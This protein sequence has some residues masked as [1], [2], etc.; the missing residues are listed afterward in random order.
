MI[1]AALLCGSATASEATSSTV[2]TE[3]AQITPQAGAGAIKNY[4]A[5]KT[6][7]FVNNYGHNVDD[8]IWKSE[9][10]WGV[11]RFNNTA[12][13]LQFRE[14]D[15]NESGRMKMRVFNNKIKL[16]DEND[17]VFS[18]VDALTPK[19]MATEDEGYTRLFK[20]KADARAYR[21]KLR[22]RDKGFTSAMLDGKT[23][24]AVSIDNYEYMTLQFDEG[25]ITLINDGKEKT[26]SY[27]IVDGIIHVHGTVNANLYLARKMPG[28]LEGVASGRRGDYVDCTRWFK[29]TYGRGVAAFNDDAKK[30]ALYFV[31][32][33]LR[34]HKVTRD[35]RILGNPEGYW[36]AE[37]NEFHFRIAKDG[38]LS[39]E[40]YRLD[41]AKIY[42]RDWDNENSPMRLY[43]DEAA[44]QAFLTRVKEGDT[45]V[46][47]RRRIEGKK[48][49]VNLGANNYKKMVVGFKFDTN[50]TMSFQAFDSKKGTFE[51]LEEHPYK[52]NLKRHE[53]VTK[54]QDGISRHRIIDHGKNWIAIREDSGEISYFYTNRLA[55]TNGI[56]HIWGEHGEGDDTEYHL[57]E[58]RVS[59]YDDQG[60]PAAV[61]GDAWVRITPKD[62]DGTYHYDNR[63]SCRVESNGSFKDSCYI[64]EYSI[65]YINQALADDNTLY[66]IVVFKN[67]VKPD[68]HHWECGED[69]Y[70]YVGHDLP[71]SD[72]SAIEVTPDD[73]QDH[74]GE[75]CH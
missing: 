23:F 66:Q 14:F 28:Y 40:A 9:A 4:I 67:T 7:Y 41:G 16:F 15:G 33:G 36:K 56:I 2:E 35:N 8:V 54:K 42:H 62:Q 30:L 19:F 53:I 57:S 12:T 74:S 48:L 32:H 25:S 55:A 52:L 73:Y 50:G 65:D 22:N 72:W 26:V 6:F 68:E 24:Y 37:G 58:G 11:V 17:T 63:I 3:S 70:K 51:T 13:R 47:L 45:G 46:A 21:N 39:F 69:L 34:G 59:F 60:N 44:A 75:D 1:V 49:Y 10:S 64:H 71:Q 31:N 18:Y 29:N 61:P 38:E 43:T 5:G 20:S 27:D